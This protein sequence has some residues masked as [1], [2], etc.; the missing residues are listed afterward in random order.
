VPRL[1][2]DSTL[3]ALTQL[4]T[5]RLGVGRAMISLVDDQR[6]Y[7]LAE[8]TPNLSLRPE[9]P[10]DASSKLWLG[11]VSIPRNCGMCEKVLNIDIQDFTLNHYPSLI[12]KDIKENVEQIGRAYIKLTSVRFYAGVPLLSPSGAIVGSL[13]IMDDMPRPDGLSKEHQNILRELAESAV[14]YLHN[15]TIKDQ[16]RRGEQ[17]TRGLISFSEGASALLPFDNVTQQDPQ[18][19]FKMS[20]PSD[21]SMSPAL[22]RTDPLDAPQQSK[23]PSSSTVRFK[24]GKQRSIKKLQENGKYTYTNLHVRQTLTSPYASRSTSHQ[25]GIHVYTG[26]QRHDGV[27]QPGWCGNTRCVCR[28]KSIATSPRQSRSYN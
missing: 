16:Y 18:A 9:A 12:I 26:S 27:Q 11:S 17:F 3:T 28:G 5:L 4:A 21:D 22:E 10:E 2:P 23:S 6:Q 25:L 19:P 13:C 14:D 15:Y 24:G 1:S 20:L 8:A 7:I